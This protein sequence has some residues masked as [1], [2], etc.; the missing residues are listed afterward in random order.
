MSYRGDF[1][2]QQTVRFTF[3][4]RDPATGALATIT[5]SP[6]LAVYKD[7][8]TT[9]ITTGPALTVDF[10][11]RTGLHLV[12]ITTTNASYTAGSDYFVVLTAGTVAGV[13]IT[14]SEVGSF[15]IE[16]RFINAS[17]LT[18]AAIAKIRN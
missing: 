14:N 10:D 15:S 8:G 13:A 3:N 7:G 6:T 12:T 2:F 1:S 11:G 17:N 16:N 18:T 4:T 9:E 5:G